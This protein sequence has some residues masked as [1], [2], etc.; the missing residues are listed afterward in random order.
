MTFAARLDGSPVNVEV[1][2]EVLRAGSVEFPY[3]DMD[4]V[5]VEDWTVL[6]RG[7][8]RDLALTQLGRGRDRF[9]QDLRAARLP[10]RR[11]AMLQSG[12]AAMI[13]A[14]EAK[15]GDEPVLVGLHSD[16]VTVESD[17]GV[18]T[19][20]PLSCITAVERDGY[21]ITIR[22][23]GMDPVVVRQMG[24]R[25]D[26]FLADLERARAELSEKT[27]AA[28][29]ELDPALGSLGAPDGWAVTSAEAGAL[30]G[31]LRAAF[32]AQ[33]RAAEIEVLA[34]LAGEKLRLGLKASFGGATMPFALVPAAGR[35]AVEGAGPEARATFV[36]EAADVDRLNLVLLLTS[37]RREALY[38]PEGELGRWSVAVRMLEEV[39]W[40]RAALRARIVHDAGWEEQVRRAL[41]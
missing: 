9:L 35:V 38:L 29:A 25:T 1:L 15:R 22:A 26:E 5:R 8:G 17:A 18:P 24:T 34:A 23:R 41:S 19:Y 16:G 28:Y 31:P 2:T 12:A 30:W 10:A 33:D 27:H 21:T 39:R 32:G 40:A 6:M 36:F 13:D 4:E 3:V 11:A 37:F 7:P 14:Y 20:L